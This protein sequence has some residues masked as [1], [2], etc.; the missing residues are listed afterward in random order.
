MNTLIRLKRKEIGRRQTTVLG[1]GHCAAVQYQNCVRFA[2]IL[3]KQGP[4]EGD[5]AW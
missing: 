3:A 1:R 4:D 5:A 2:R